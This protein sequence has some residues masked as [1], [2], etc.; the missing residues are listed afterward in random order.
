MLRTCAA[1]HRSCAAAASRPP[2]R[3]RRPDVRGHPGRAAGDVDPSK[4]VLPEP[5]CVV[6]RPLGCDMRGGRE[7]CFLHLL[8]RGCRTIFFPK[9]PLSDLHCSNLRYPPER[10]RR[11]QK[12]E[13]P[14]LE[15]GLHYPLL[16]AL[17]WSSGVWCR[18]CALWGTSCTPRR[19]LCL[20]VCLSVC[21]ILSC[22]SASGPPSTEIR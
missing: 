14:P 7:G 3:P 12:L 13:N 21:L 5:D 19:F 10:R 9:T 8:P 6:S 20:S 17:E 22:L 16:R 18:R 4:A 15:S 1:G 11:R 2:A